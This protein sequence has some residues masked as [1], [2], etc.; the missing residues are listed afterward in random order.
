V[1]EI[2]LDYITRRYKIDDMRVTGMKITEAKIN[3][4]FTRKRWLLV[5]SYTNAVST[6]SSRLSS[7]NVNEWSIN[8]F[9]KL[10]S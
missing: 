9:N 2:I 6:K 10:A 5:G 8:L 3:R 4:M 7:K 1:F